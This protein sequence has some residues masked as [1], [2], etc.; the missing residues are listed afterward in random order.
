MELGQ[1]GVSMKYKSTL[2]MVGVVFGCARGPASVTTPQG[3]KPLNDPNKPTFTEVFGQ[4]IGPK[5]ATCHSAAGGNRGGVN[6]ETFD[7]VKANISMIK[8]AVAAGWMP[9]RSQAALSGAEKDLVLR[10]IDQ[11]A[12]NN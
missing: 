2:M 4:V 1:M 6:L 7:G 10:W 8:D 9:P 3:E 12:L 5:C 11:G